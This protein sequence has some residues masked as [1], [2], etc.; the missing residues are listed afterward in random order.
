MISRIILG[1]MVL[2]L[3]GCGSSLT[4]RSDGATEDVGLI[5]EEFSEVPEASASGSE[6]L[7][8][9]G[10]LDGEFSEDGL[11]DF[12][13]MA[14]ED[15]DNGGSFDDFGDVAMEDEP[16]SSSPTPTLPE[17][18][19]GFD[20]MD[21]VASL[22]DDTGPDPL[23]GMTGGFEISDSMDQSF[24]DSLTGS[25]NDAVTSPI[26]DS[27]IDEPPV[28]KFE[29]NRITALEYDSDLRGGSVVIRARRNLEFNT[30]YDAKAQQYIIDIENTK[31]PDIYKRPLFMKDF[32]QSFGAVSSYENT[33][34]T[35]RVI[36]QLK[37]DIEPN[38][39]VQEKGLVVSP[40]TALVSG[41]ATSSGLAPNRK[42]VPNV[43]NME[44]FLLEN[45]DF[46]GDLISLQ[47]ND[48]ELTAVI[49]FIADQA[50]ANVVVGQGVEGKISLKLRDVPWDQALMTIM[51]THNLG[52]IRTGNVLR[53]S[54]LEDL[55]KE[56]DAAIKIQE[57][58]VKL[59]PVIIKVVPL[60]YASPIEV[61]KQL[62]PLSTKD[63]G[64]LFSD[65]RTSSIIINDTLSNINKM[66]A[67]L[68]ELD[69]P[70]PQVLIEAKIVEASREFARDIGLR[71][72]V[73]GANTQLGNFG[74]QQISIFPSFRVNNIQGNLGQ[75]TTG[76]D[77]LSVGLRIG[78]F[79]FLGN[80]N[81][82]LNLKE[83][84]KQIKIISSPRVVTLNNQQA[85]ILQATEI[86][87][88][89]VTFAGAGSGLGQAEPVAIPLELTMKVTPQITTDASVLLDVDVK[90][91]FPGAADQSGLSPKNTR[92]AKTKVLVDNNKTAVIGGIFQNDT[93]DTEIG[94][95]ILRHIP[96]FGWLFKTK[97]LTKIDTEL[98]I[99]ITPR[100]LDKNYMSS[101]ALA[102]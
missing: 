46:T 6:T 8:M 27:M 99:F 91:E 59:E 14:F 94:V 45:T 55:E 24:E 35:A 95:P 1:L 93:T 18:D 38:V 34:G 50:G 30:Q 58:Q 67:L 75:V 47:V 80:I 81:A 2:S 84:D 49:N 39:S 76:T 12:D 54:K 102:N 88:Q 51:K 64:N 44:E 79:D 5:N 10:E 15:E 42:S 98:M 61:E 43:N 53:I 9:E 25:F 83:E 4:N 87:R 78:S 65:A 40:G 20:D 68:R 70:P 82:L 97:G 13:G 21:D 74:G 85:E 29:P 36:I 71:W 60:K 19:W 33:D 96:I 101:D 86:L 89:R 90:R 63:R 41:M 3:V 11:D 92:Q 37:N 77:P 7:D 69:T 56:A 62:K 16:S 26:T 57:S 23:E 28:N 48:E 32:E 66:V 17:D 52:Y 100:I 31:I 72:G 22:P 73:M